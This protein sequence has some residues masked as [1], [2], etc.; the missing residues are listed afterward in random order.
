MTNQLLC[1]HSETRKQLL[2]NRVHV[3]LL[4][5]DKAYALVMGGGAQCPPTKKSDSESENE[6]HENQPQLKRAS[7]NFEFLSLTHLL[8]WSKTATSH[9]GPPCS[10]RQSEGALVLC[11]RQPVDA[12]SA[13]STSL[14]IPLA[15][16]R[17]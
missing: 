6:H 11:T 3:L 16:R 14:F 7:V 9:Q 8:T 15:N 5:W 12:K 17:V 2:L 10:V 4:N 13:A 1:C